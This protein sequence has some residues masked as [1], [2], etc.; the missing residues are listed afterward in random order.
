M[1]AQQ[2]AQQQQ[3]PLIQMQMMD[4]QIKQLVAQ[5]KAQQMQIDAQLRQA[6]IQRKQQKDLLDAASKEDD[7]RLRQAEIAARNELDAARLGVDIQKHKIEQDFVEKSAGVQMGID[8]AKAREAAAMQRE[9][10]KSPKE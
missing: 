6:E 10:S 8:I 4:L 9:K 1:Q 5:T 7:L 3:D 2:V